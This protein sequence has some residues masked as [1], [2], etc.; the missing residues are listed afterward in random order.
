MTTTGEAYCWGSNDSGRLGD[1]TTAQRITPVLVSGGN[2]W[3]SV[4]AGGDHTC[5][6]TTASDAYCWGYNDNGQLGDGTTRVHLGPHKVSGGHSWASVSADQN[7]T[8]GVTTADE[9][10]C[11]GSNSNGQLGDGTTR[12]NSTTPVLVS[13]VYSWASVSTGL[14]HTCG[15]TTTG[16]AYCWGS[17]GRGRLGD[18]TTIHRFAPGKVGGW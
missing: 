7:H 3:A 15:V 11:W 4:S 17:N 9:A 14:L 1:G 2:S 12:A 6:V 16:E 13:G 5:G 18:G 10:Y 8:C